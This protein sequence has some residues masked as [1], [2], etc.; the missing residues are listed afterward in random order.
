MLKCPHVEFNVSARES[1]LLGFAF[2]LRGLALGNNFKLP[3]FFV[4]QTVELLKRFTFIFN[5]KL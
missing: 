5:V 3:T 2:F 1:D 4:I